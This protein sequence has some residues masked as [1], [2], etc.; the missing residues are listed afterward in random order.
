[1]EKSASKGEGLINGGIYLLNKRL[2]QDFQVGQNFSFEKDIMEKR[3]YTNNYYAQ[4][5]NGYFI[6]IGVPE[7]YYRAQKEL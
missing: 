5:S 7:D 3:V 4:V 6:D 1:M 2:M